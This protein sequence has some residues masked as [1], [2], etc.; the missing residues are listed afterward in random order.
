VYPS[1]LLCVNAHFRRQTEFEQ[2]VNVIELFLSELDKVGELAVWGVV[3][4]L[5]AGF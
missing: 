5:V 3:G 2:L 1:D 4:H